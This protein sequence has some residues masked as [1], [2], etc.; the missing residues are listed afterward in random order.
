MKLLSASIKNYRC[1]AGEDSLDVEFNEHLHVIHGDNES[2][3]STLVN[4]VHDAL[5]LKASGQSQKHTQIRPRDKSTP[6]IGVAFEHEDSIFT[7]A[8][9]FKGATGTCTLSVTRPNGKVDTFAGDEAETALCEAL[10]VKRSSSRS[11]EPDF[12]HW[13][14][15]W[16][17]QGHSASP[18]AEQVDSETQG[19]LERL[20]QAQ[21]GQVLGG[22]QDSALMAKVEEEWGKRFTGG[23]KTI[24]GSD[25]ANSE[26]E[27]SR[28]KAQLDELT[29]QYKGMEHY[30]DEHDRLQK[31]CIAIDEL[32][33]V[34]QDKVRELRKT[35]SR[36]KTIAANVDAVEK[37]M[38]L[39]ARDL[40]DA[41]KR[42][43]EFEGMQAELISAKD[44][45][46]AAGESD[47]HIRT[48]ARELQKEYGSLQ[49]KVKSLTEDA[50]E[51][52]RLVRRVRAHRDLLRA[53]LDSE[54]LAIQLKE[55]DA[56]DVCKNELIENLS[57]VSVT[58]ELVDKARKL[59]T[60]CVAARARLDAVSAQLR[61]IAKERV[62]KVG[63]TET[64]ADPGTELL[65]K[66]SE[67]AEFLIGEEYARIE[68]M[69]GGEDLGARRQALETTEAKFSECLR[70][71][72]CTELS[73]AETSLASRRSKEEEL[74]ST[75]DKL[76]VLA[77]KGVEVLR[78]EARHAVAQ[79]KTASE[80][81]E[82]ETND[83]DP[84]L[85][86]KSADADD[87]MALIESDADTA[88]HTRD[89]ARSTLAE[90]DV[91]K[92][93]LEEKQTHSAGNVKA[94]S[95]LVEQLQDRIK[96]ATAVHGDIEKLKEAVA[97]AEI[98]AAEAERVLAKSKKELEELDPENV[99]SDLQRS[100]KAVEG[101]RDELL[102]KRSDLG[103]L[104]GR[105]D[106][107]DEFLG[108]HERIGDLHAQL[109]QEETS[110]DR[111]R[112]VAKAWGL[113]RT[114]LLAARKTATEQVMRPLCEAVLPMLNI[115]FPEANVHF[116]PGKGGRLALA[117]ISRGIQTD[118]F[119][120]LSQ[121]TREQIGVI[122]RLGLAKVL[123]RQ[124]GGCLPVV[125]DDAL[126]S[127]DPTRRERMLSVLDRARR[128][129]QVI[130][131]TCDFGHYRELGL[132]PPQITEL[133][134]RTSDT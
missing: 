78:A 97:S 22:A 62:Q 84:A 11:A 8:K 26:A 102:G 99:E 111:A 103:K 67:P 18:P 91:K 60:E 39:K 106:D 134:K 51:S 43:Q 46:V 7:V 95:S 63:D 48:T 50:A 132:S 96:E 47:T 65:L 98:A 128:D 93:Q 133:A 92:A 112:T 104:S 42:L 1:H 40:E 109:G 116:E 108:L 130:V 21:T 41:R 100:E 73:G 113:L 66:V 76:K 71:M 120:E 121:G 114:H 2:G 19:M 36:C 75:S 81:V 23:G 55:A 17:G 125:L 117:P 54:R 45:L 35:S 15:L 107:E 52:E 5:F 32:I 85:P 4:A 3:K 16:V 123:A 10:G 90:W 25:V 70:E 68:I 94:K 86:S 72:H 131:L 30:A 38:L 34:E 20:L 122:V 115:V 101:Y 74:R 126:V 61:I 6:E 14:V 56:L 28:L 110:L 44:E 13:N 105:F 12:A 29:K 24:K 77:S 31:E 57:S 119:E 79:F 82:R 9:A 37:K 64:F 80:N 87:H 118:D 58:D 89:A 124:F 27:V 127:S 129:L 59:N 69:P 53:G 83:G 33:P 88:V 49:Q